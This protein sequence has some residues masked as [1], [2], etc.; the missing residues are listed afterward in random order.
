MSSKYK[1]QFDL[2][3][4]VALVTG[5]A[6]IIGQEVCRGLAEFGANVAVVDVNLSGI[7]ILIAELRG[8]YR[9][10]VEGFECDVG[11]PESVSALYDGVMDRFGSVNVLHNNAASKSSSLDRFFAPFEEYSLKTWREV[12]AV[13]VDGMFLMAQAFGKEMARNGGGSI[14]QTASI[15]GLV[16]PDQRIYEGSR[17]MNREISSPAVYSASKAAVLGMTR[18]LAAYWGDSGVRV[19]AITPGG[20][21]SGQNSVFSEKYSNR[22]PMRRMASASEMV[23]AV[24]YLASDASSYVTGQNLIVDG[25][26]TA[27]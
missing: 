27:W 1:E 25:G 21:E 14:I 2:Q 19:N 22:V 18:Y 9:V 7:E 15:Y 5:G 4:K 24:I 20:V 17:Y 10:D 8:K 12:M 13:N 23:S 3:G 6:G 11:S 16:A 26:L